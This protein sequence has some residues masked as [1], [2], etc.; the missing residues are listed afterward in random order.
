MPL[1]RRRS[2]RSGRQMPKGRRVWGGFTTVDLDGLR[3]PV[4]LD[5]NEF[6]HTWILNPADAQEF[7]DEPTLMRVLMNFAANIEL[8]TTE[9]LGNFGADVYFTL[10][11]LS[12]DDLAGPAFKNPIDTTQQ[13]VFW[14]NNFLFHRT[15]G[16]VSWQFISLGVDQ[17]TGFMDIK[18]RRKIPEGF[19]LSAQIWNN[20]NIGV[21]FDPAPITFFS[22]GRV[23]FNDH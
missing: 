23:L 11:V 9:A 16:A 6:A 1:R 3:S 18:T 20:D 10:S 5:P 21:D 12:E 22:A 14:Y 2:G 13:W 15:S 4:R 17:R 7:Y 8:T 19:G